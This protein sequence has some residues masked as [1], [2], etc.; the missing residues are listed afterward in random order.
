[1]AKNI[2]KIAEAPQRKILDGKRPQR[3]ESPSPVSPVIEELSRL[4][5]ERTFTSE[6]EGLAFLIE[7]VVTKLEGDP[8]AQGEMRDFL[9]LLLET[10]PILREEILVNLKIEG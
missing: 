7:S 5:S 4:S 1:M 6:E 8:T 2:R 10:D 3:N 9:H